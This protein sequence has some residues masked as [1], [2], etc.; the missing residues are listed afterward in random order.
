MLMKKSILLILFAMV[1]SFIITS[2]STQDD[3]ISEMEQTELESPATDGDDNDEV[4]P[5]SSGN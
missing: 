1:F 2:C 4:P 3:V 5:G